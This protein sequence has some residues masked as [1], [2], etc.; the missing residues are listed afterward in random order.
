M[1]EQS[2]FRTEAQRRYPTATLCNVGP[3]GV[4]LNGGRIVIEMFRTYE[5]AKKFAGGVF[6]IE[7]FGPKVEPK[8]FR[9]KMDT[10]DD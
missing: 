3:Y 1:A 9:H 2:T 5:D 4:V 6:R 8:P 7:Y 10:E